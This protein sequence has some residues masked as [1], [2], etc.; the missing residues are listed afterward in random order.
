MIRS[1]IPEGAKRSLEIS[2]DGDRWLPLLRYTELIQL[3]GIDTAGQVPEGTGWGMLETPAIIPLFG[4]IAE[5]KA[6][7]RLVVRNQARAPHET[8][9]LHVVRGAP[10][11]VLT[12]DPE[13][14][15]P[16]QLIA[17]KLLDAAM[18]ER[19]LHISALHGQALDEVIALKTGIDIGDYRP[20]L[21]LFRLEPLLAWGS[22]LFAFAQTQPEKVEPFAQSLLALLPPLVQRTRST[23]HLRRLLQGSMEVT[24]ERVPNFD[25]V[26]REFALTNA[27][28]TGINP[29]GQTRTLEE[30]LRC[31]L[32]GEK[33]AMTMAYI[34]VHLGLLRPKTRSFSSIPPFPR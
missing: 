8:I 26:V 15:L 13:V 28:L 6:T 29:L 9:E 10:T 24:F 18:L 34:L 19:C 14:D 31:S 7:G 11:H 33:F 2:A 20:R 16:R 21:M 30:A 25:E 22:A 17:H 32:G 23:E 3:D 4:R 5:H 27:Q 1:R 12:S